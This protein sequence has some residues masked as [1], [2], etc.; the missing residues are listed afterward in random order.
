MFAYKS[1]SLANVDS[2][3][4]FVVSGGNK[5]VWTRGGDALALA[6]AACVR[7]NDRGI[8]LYPDHWGLRDLSLLFSIVLPCLPAPGGLCTTE[9]G[10]VFS[11]TA[12]PRVNLH[13]PGSPFSTLAC[14]SENTQQQATLERVYDVSACNVLGQG[15]D[16]IYFDRHLYMRVSKI[17][18]WEYSALCLLCVYSVRGFS[19]ILMDDKIEHK[20]FTHIM[21]CTVL[22]T[23]FCLLPGTNIYVSTEDLISFIYVLLVLAF[24]MVIYTVNYIYHPFSWFPSVNVVL[25]VF[26]LVSMRLYQ[27][28][29]SPFIPMLLWAIGTR[30]IVKL[31][32]LEWSVVTFLSMIADSF[33]ISILYVWGCTLSYSVSIALGYVA[34]ICAYLVIAKIS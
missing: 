4:P 9:Y 1:M 18:W 3:T 11:A 27:G 24:D 7:V 34:C 21:L 19:N 10:A 12:V 33:L 2:N 25:T 8:M 15:G 14:V 22:M 29:I 13:I 16:I 28:V 23:I 26:V 17:S 30:F 31:Q 5:V 20:N 32:V 6:R